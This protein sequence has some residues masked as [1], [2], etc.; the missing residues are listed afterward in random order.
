[1]IADFVAKVQTVAAD[2]SGM[3]ATRLAEAQSLNASD[4]PF[5]EVIVGPGVWDMGTTGWP[6]Q[7]RELSVKFYVASVNS[8]IIPDDAYTKGITLL[9]QAGL[10]LLNDR[11]LLGTVKGIQQFGDTGIVVLS[12]AGI[13]YWGFE[14]RFQVP[15]FYEPFDN[16]NGTPAQPLDNAHLS[17]A[18]TGDVHT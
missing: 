9:E 12:K 4:L 13:D 5:A 15:E 16:W 7:Q 2:I 10:T 11:T 1:M 3:I 14:F 18:V 6:A 8:G 17:G